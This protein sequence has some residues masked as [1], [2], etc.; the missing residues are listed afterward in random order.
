MRDA[1]FDAVVIGGGLAGASAAHALA[2]RGLAVCLCEAQ[3]SLALGASGNPYGLLMP[4]ISDRE[5]PFAELYSSGFL[6]SLALFQEHF[7]DSAP[8]AKSGGLQ[9]PATERLRKL[10]AGR[11]SLVHAPTVRRLSPTESSEVA[12][13]RLSSPA[14]YAPLAGFIS[15]PRLVRAMSALPKISVMHRAVCRITPNVSGWSCHLAGQVAL[16]CKILV[17]ANAFEA[18]SLPQLAWLPLEPVR[19]QTCLLKGSGSSAALRTLVCFDGYITPLSEGRHLLGAHYRHGDLRR[20]PDD[21]D[22]QEILQRAAAWLPSL[23]LSA[24]S[25][26]DSRVCFRTSTLDRLPYIGEIPDVAQMSRDA[27]QFQS[28]TD[29]LSKVPT[30]RLPRAFISAGHGSR[31]LH[32]C[33]IAGE[34]IARLACDEPMAELRGV[35]QACDP[36]RIARRVVGGS[37]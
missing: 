21:D 8:F 22:T 4:Y 30:Q 17:V 5:S 18:R 15:P 7:A 34:I 24:S 20:A 6:F 9:L 12:G 11:T 19:G 1:S 32:S 26:Y 33:P 2:R 27:A 10:I 31:G 25:P 13:I 16:S 35:A 29:V 28:G 3:P 37:L 14:F 23:S 36:L